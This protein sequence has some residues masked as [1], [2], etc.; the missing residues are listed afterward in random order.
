MTKAIQ[1]GI[2][3]CLVTKPSKKP[4]TIKNGMVLNMIFKPSLKFTDN[5]YALTLFC[6]QILSSSA[7]MI[8]NSCCPFKKNDFISYYTI[9]VS[10]VRENKRSVQKHRSCFLPYIHLI[11]NTSKLCKRSNNL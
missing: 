3:V 4:A 2:S 7:K 11:R 6:L 5:D 1:S 9:L 8:L 10:Y